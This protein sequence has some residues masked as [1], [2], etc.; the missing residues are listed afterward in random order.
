V[1]IALRILILTGLLLPAGTRLYSQQAAPAAAEPVQAEDKTAPSYDLKAQA[2]L[3]LQQMQQKFTTLAAATP[4]EKFSWRPAEGIRSVGEIFL[5][6]AAAEFNFPV[7]G[8]ATPAQGFQAKG[9]EKSTTD[10]TQIIEWLNKSFAF[11]IASVQNMSN[12]DFAVLLPKLGPQANKG[13][14]V[15][16]NVVHA[17]EML[18]QAIAYSRSI[19]VV[20]PW[21]AAQK[22]APQTP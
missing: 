11:S 18:G 7:M 1:K 15:Y 20:P 3:D 21:T 16:L 9:F 4:Q 2:V 22:K 17:H 6:T 8:G 12:A 14:V 19:G 10:K 5:H 13:D